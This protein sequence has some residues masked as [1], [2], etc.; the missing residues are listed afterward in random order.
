METVIGVVERITFYNDENGYTVLRLM[1]E[2][3]YPEAQARDGTIAVVGVMPELN[4]GESLQ[5]TGQWVDDPRYGR[6]L[7][8]ETVI[9][10][11]PST[12][13]GIV[14]YLS[15]G[16]VSGIGPKTAERIVDHFGDETLNILDL[17]PDRIDEVPGLRPELAQKLKI[18]W[19]NNR[20]MRQSLIYLQGYG[21]SSRL[22]Q[23]IYAQYGDETIALIKKDPYQLADDIFGVG[24]KKADAI[25]RSMG[26]KHD[27]PERLRAGLAYALNHL[28]LEGHTY[29]PREV[30]LQTASELLE[31]AD[32]AR[33]AAALDAQIVAGELKE[34]A[35][36]LP[37]GERQQAIYLPM[38]F[39]A[40]RGGA[41]LL[42]ALARTKSKIILQSEKIKWDVFLGELAEQNDISL[43]KQQQSAVKAALT[44]KVSVL[45]GGPGTGKTTTLRMVIHALEEKAYRYALASPTGRA[46][47][48]LS[49]ATNRPASTI[50][51]L[52]EFNPMDGGFQRD[53]DNPLEL[54][55]LVVDEASMLDLLL[56]YNLLK[57]LPAHAHLLLVGDIDQLPSVGAGNVL[58]DIIESGV[59]HVT[60]LDQIFRQSEASYI[61]V[62]AHRVNQGEMP[63]TDNR[64]NDF[65]FFSDTDPQSAAD[66]LVDVVYN[67]LPEKFGYDPMND[68]QVIAPMYRGPVGVHALNR[69]LQ[70][71]LNGDKRMAEK[72]LNGTLF[73]VGDK[74]MQT[75][76]NY[77]KE[78]FNGDIGRIYG[79]DFEENQLE[80]VID[81]RYLYYD[82]AS[83]ADQ[84]IL[85]YCISTHR[86]QGSEYPVVVMPVMT[87]HYMMLQ[88][89]LLYTAI[90]RAKEVVVL[91]G[92]RKA[93]AMA[94]RNNKVAERFSGLLERLRR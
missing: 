55:F 26:L 7:K 13:E 85:A 46:A 66:L 42:N 1:P 48:R 50:H 78:V 70:Q 57:A 15:S 33:I 65:F 87:Q 10:L 16:I 60:R 12:R 23:K 21:I 17:S 62:N 31:V 2:G 71:K 43:T 53:E 75:K 86:S 79:I 69:A 92:D 24:F 40:E 19:K 51:R 25:A 39:Y 72:S 83:E 64:G 59:A 38:Y 91:V 14:R 20:N 32:K 6:Q 27:A 18:A 84:L 54:D 77:E 47:K 4:E 73:R 67:R 28:A 80:V 63:Y 52:L 8:I 90:T 93:I 35:L 36:I 94:V 89:N 3:N 11:E 5:V 34:D 81:G 9:P 76:N 82:W 74:I 56:F 61:I 58:R 68:I 30:L 29:A 49:E 37:S 44:G 41:S 88:R 22:A 45:T